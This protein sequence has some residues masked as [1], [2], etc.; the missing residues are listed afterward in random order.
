MLKSWLDL[1]F[2]FKVIGSVCIA[3]GMCFQWLCIQTS[4]FPG[5]CKLT[6]T[7]ELLSAPMCGNRVTF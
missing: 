7:A 3:V 1:D 5:K 4:V 6:L 2:L